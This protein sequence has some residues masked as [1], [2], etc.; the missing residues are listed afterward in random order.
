[1]MKRV[2]VWLLAVSIVTSA[3]ALSSCG[4]TEDVTDKNDGIL[5]EEDKILSPAFGGDKLDF[6]NEDFLVMTKNDHTANT[7][8]FSAILLF[9]RNKK[10]NRKYIKQ[11]KEKVNLG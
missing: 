4:K 3:V 8:Y 11:E 6:E 9:S 10:T 7:R 1:M 2:I 5:G